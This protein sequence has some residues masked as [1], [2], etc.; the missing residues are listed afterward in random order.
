M[1]EDES[2]QDEG[3]GLPP[4]P[5]IPP[6][7]ARAWLDVVHPEHLSIS[8]T[9]I[10]SRLQYIAAQVHHLAG[11]VEDLRSAISRGQSRRGSMSSSTA[12]STEGGDDTSVTPIPSDRVQEAFNELRTGELREILTALHDSFV[13]VNNKKLHV[14]RI[15]NANKDARTFIEHVTE[16]IKEKQANPEGQEEGVAEN[17]EKMLGHL[18]NLTPDLKMDL[19][20]ELNKAKKQ[21]DNPKGQGKAKAKHAGSPILIGTDDSDHQSTTSHAGP[22]TTVT[23]NQQASARP[24]RKASNSSQGNGQPRRH[25]SRQT[26]RSDRVKGEQ[27][28]Q[29]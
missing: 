6:E 24:S 28:Q 7:F 19:Y 5:T 1:S 17:H 29:S 25:P 18:A 11:Q 20:I 16:V 4:A 22:S 14:Q 12:A 2:Y 26:S 21:R 15:I 27:S 8:E 13:A 23:Q 10:L 3:L 9:V